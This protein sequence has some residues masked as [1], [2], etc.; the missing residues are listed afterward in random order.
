VQP[1]F[2]TECSSVVLNVR[3]PHKKLTF[4]LLHIVDHF[5]NGCSC[6]CASPGMKKMCSFYLQMLWLCYVVIDEALEFLH[7]VKDLLLDAL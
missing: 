3:N 7:P 5:S 2:S 4:V 6:K 1:N